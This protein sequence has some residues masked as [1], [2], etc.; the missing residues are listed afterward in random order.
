MDDM[1]A[2]SLG[3]FA[4]WAAHDVEEWL[5]MSENSAGVLGR[6][7][8]ILPLPHDL[9]QRGISQRHVNLSL[10]T[11]A[12]IIATVSAS[13]VRSRGRSPFFQGRRSR[14]WNPRYYAYGCQYAGT[15]LHYRRCYRS[16]YCHSLLALGEQK[17]A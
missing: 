11:M 2:V 16:D 9:A 12:G 10:A 7:S 4:A 1:T 6:V 3:L 5:T 13:G 8:K 17:T 14:V 15:G